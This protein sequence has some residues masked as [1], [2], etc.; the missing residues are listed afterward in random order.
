MITRNFNSIKTFLSKNKQ[1][2]VVGA[3]L[4]LTLAIVVSAFV[5]IYSLLRNLFPHII[6]LPVSE[7]S[8]ILQLSSIFCVR[9]FFF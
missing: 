2:I 8:L 7:T 5:L 4:I 9:S 1:K 6:C 3:V